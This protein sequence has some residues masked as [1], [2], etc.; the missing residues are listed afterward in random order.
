MGEKPDPTVRHKR[1]EHVALVLAGLVVLGLLVYAVVP[2]GIR[3]QPSFYGTAAQVIPLLI[4]AIAVERVWHPGWR[5]ELLLLV[6]RLLVVGELAA[7]VG[8]AYD[9]REKGQADYLVA[10]SR[11][12]TDM[13]EYF[14]VV[15]I[16]VGLMAVLWSTVFRSDVNAGSDRTQ[17]PGASRHPPEP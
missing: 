11:L 14:A 4:L 2:G 9:V 7:L 17:R 10:S 1:V 16:G 5:F 15:G 3:A 6:V 12:V 8:N 13:L